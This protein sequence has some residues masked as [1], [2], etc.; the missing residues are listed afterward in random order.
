MNKKLLKEILSYVIIIAIV[1]LIRTFLVT[2]VKV[3]GNSMDPTLK[4]EEI[5]ILNKIKY[6]TTKIKRFDIVVIKY[7]DE[8]LIKR[9]IGL[10]GDKIEFKDNTLY[11]N[12]EKVKENFKHD[13]TEDFSLSSL[14]YEFVPNGKY[15]VMGDNRDDSLDSRIF[16]PV[17]KERILGSANLV[18]FPFT[19]IGIKK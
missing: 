2:P 16:G 14:E 10:P 8:L 15:F 6:K 17:E 11:V 9:V 1:I 18:L 13:K 7:N 12:D 3:N 4:H 19:K 5:M